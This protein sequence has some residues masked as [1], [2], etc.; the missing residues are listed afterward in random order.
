M[1]RKEWCVHRP[2]LRIMVILWENGK[3]LRVDPLE[4]LA[5][6]WL[7]EK[8]EPFQKMKAN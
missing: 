3:E 7:K 1:K 2:S 4:I 5:Y 8:N 6:S